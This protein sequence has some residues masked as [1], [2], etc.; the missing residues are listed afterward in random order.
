MNALNLFNLIPTDLMSLIPMSN[1][2][3]AIT[4]MLTDPFFLDI[5]GFDGGGIWSLIEGIGF[6]GI[7]NAVVL[8]PTASPKNC[9]GT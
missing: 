8:S 6:G 2:G 3:K 1:I 9:S 7:G 4:N 5:G